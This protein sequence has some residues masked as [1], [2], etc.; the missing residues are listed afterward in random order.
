MWP[1][2]PIVAGD[3]HREDGGESEGDHEQRDARSPAALIVHPQNEGDHRKRVPDQG[4]SQS[5]DHEPQVA[6]APDRAP[7]FL[8]SVT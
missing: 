1:A 4:D 3:T 8:T 2:T 5:W 7:A 6:V